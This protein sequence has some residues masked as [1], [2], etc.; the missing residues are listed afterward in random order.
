MSSPTM[1]QRGLST[2]FTEHL[3]LKDLSPKLLQLVTTDPLTNF[4][5]LRPK[6]SNPLFFTWYNL[7]YIGWPHKDHKWHKFLF[8]IQNNRQFLLNETNP[9]NIL[10][11]K[12]SDISILN[13]TRLRAILEKHYIRKWKPEFEELL[14]PGAKGHWFC[15]KDNIRCQFKP[16]SSGKSNDSV[17]P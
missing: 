9:N 7:T 6:S 1:R 12:A 14:F 15:A 4:S 5:V 8:N 2:I 17:L 3:S 10:I 11:E 16:N 13:Q